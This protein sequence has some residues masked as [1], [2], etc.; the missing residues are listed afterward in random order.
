MMGNIPTMS[1][2]LT[3]WYRRHRRD[4]PWRPR[5]DAPRGTRPQAYHVLVSEAMLQ[6]TQVATVIPYFLRFISEFPSIRALAGADEQ[7]VLRAWQGLGYYSR[8]RNLRRAAQAILERFGGKIPSDAGKLRDLPGVGRYTAGA[9]A[10]LAFGRREPIVDGN[11]A[12]VICR[13]DRIESDPRSAATVKQIWTQAAQIL[14]RTDVADVNSALM[15]LGATVCT[16]RAPRCPACPIRKH[17]EAFAGS[18]Q[19][20]IPFPRITRKVPLVRRRTWCIRRT[21]GTGMQFLIEQRP[22]S[23]RWA[24]MWQFVTRDAAEPEPSGALE[25]AQALGRIAHALTHR[26]YEF[27][28]FLFDAHD[29]PAAAA[30]GGPRRPSRWVRLDQLGD[31]P[32]SRPQLR[33]A[34]L[35]R[36]HMGGQT[37]ARSKKIRKKNSP[38]SCILPHSRRY[39]T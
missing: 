10:S 27:E 20:R 17:C 11:V 7:R 28:V 36:D 32:L 35:L 1:A 14:P 2:R 8:A 25:Q 30:D 6:Q 26:R 21:N 38:G 37:N 12:R 29:P 24:G 39:R 3:R 13:L 31:F 34:Q 22:P 15:E 33:I 19:G 9:V 5:P 16:P 18:V 4:L 23:G